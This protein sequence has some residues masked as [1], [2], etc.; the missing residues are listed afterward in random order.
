MEYPTSNWSLLGICI[1]KALEE[2]LYQENVSE[3]CDTLWHKT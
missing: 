2:C 3:S 1:L